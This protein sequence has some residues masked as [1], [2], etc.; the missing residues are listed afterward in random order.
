MRWI[1]ANGLSWDVIKP[2][3]LA[4][5]LHPLSLEDMLHSTSSSSTRSKADYY[6]QHLFCSVIVHRTLDQP[7]VVEVPEE[8][9]GITRSTTKALKKGKERS[10]HL[11]CVVDR[12]VFSARGS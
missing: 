7:G 9:I 8:A 2:I 4:F 10:G 6:R 12:P 5:D 11:Q 1:H 3:A